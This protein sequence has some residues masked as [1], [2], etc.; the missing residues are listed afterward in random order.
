MLMVWFS[1]SGDCGGVGLVMGLVM[2]SREESI[3]GGSVR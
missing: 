1:E 2:R 3:A